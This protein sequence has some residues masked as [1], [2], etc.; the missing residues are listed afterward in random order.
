MDNMTQTSLVRGFEELMAEDATPAAEQGDV[1]SDVVVS[2]LQ[3]NDVSQNS[4]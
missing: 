3:V 2:P 4:D 1:D